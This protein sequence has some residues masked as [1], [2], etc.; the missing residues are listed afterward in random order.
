MHT[1]RVGDG[2]LVMCVFRCRSNAPRSFAKKG[3]PPKKSSELEIAG[4]ERV[5]EPPDNW[6]WHQVGKSRHYPAGRPLT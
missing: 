3:P 2:E 5:H 4:E 6:H 1:S